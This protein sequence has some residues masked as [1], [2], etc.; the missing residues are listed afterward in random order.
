MIWLFPWLSEFLVIV[1]IDSMTHIADRAS[2]LLDPRDDCNVWRQTLQ[3][4]ISG[5]KWFLALWS[6]SAVVGVQPPITH[7]FHDNVFF[8]KKNRVDKFKRGMRRSR[9]WVRCRCT[10]DKVWITLTYCVFRP[11]TA[12]RMNVWMF[13]VTA[14]GAVVAVDVISG[15]LY[16]RFMAS[17]STLAA[18]RRCKEM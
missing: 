3:P 5:E 10:F 9:S 7:L 12:H 18:S 4:D 13:V 16:T 6:A 8:L 1:A 2:R 15:R 14:P 11:E 17:L